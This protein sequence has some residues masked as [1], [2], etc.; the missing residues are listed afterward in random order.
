MNL[1]EIAMACRCQI[2][3][4]SYDGAT[5]SCECKMAK[6]CAFTL[7]E[8]QELRKHLRVIA[9]EERN[10]KELEKISESKK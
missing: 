10:S 7:E 4:G 5:R 8:R 2:L 1:I 9:A 6:D 3:T